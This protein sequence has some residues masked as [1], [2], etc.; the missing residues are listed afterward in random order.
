MPSWGVSA[1]AITRPMAF[2]RGYPDTKGVVVTSLRPGSPPDKAQPSLEAGD[3]ITEIGGKPVEDLDSFATLTKEN[4]S[5]KALSV[6]FRRGKRDMVTVLD[7]SK[8]PR[9]PRNA[10]LAKAWI[11]IRTQVLTTKVAKA[12]GLE[13]KMGF[14]ITRILPGTEAAKVDLRPGDVITAI[15][16][17]ALEAYR[18]QDGQVLTR[19]VEDMDIGAEVKLSVLR[20][21]EPLEVTVPLEETPNTAADARTGED[22]VL[23][24]KVRE[25][26]FMDRVENDL[27]KDYEGVIVSTVTPGSWAQVA[28]LRVGDILLKINDRP[29]DDLRAFKE[30]V[31][32]LAKERPKRVKIFVKRERSTAFVFMRPEWPSD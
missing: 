13:G 6:R 21:G 15:N 3:V 16:G 18:L 1:M 11:G 9:P 30:I 2:N 8:P 20:D 23:E 29:V 27:E 19:R 5:S 26:T 12:L 24:Y 4:A 25:L 7:M 10:E 22:E 14:R 17:E 31:K 28:D 32:T